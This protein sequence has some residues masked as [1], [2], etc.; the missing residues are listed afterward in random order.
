M[1]G[2]MRPDE[3]AAAKKVVIPD[4]VWDA[5]NA[6]IASRFIGGCAIVPQQAVVDKLIAAGFNEIDIFDKGWLNV[7][8]G[9]RALGWHVEYDKPGWNE[10][11]PAKYKFTAA[12]AVCATPRQQ[13]GGICEE[14]AT[15]IERLRLELAQAKL[16]E[17]AAAN[18]EA[19]IL[20]LR[21]LLRDW[22]E[23][24]KD[25]KPGCAAGA[26]WLESLRKRTALA[27]GDV[28]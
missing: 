26:D 14:A 23:F 11:Y 18:L 8:D 24:A 19:E 13:E 16:A 21:E 2:P 25:V 22:L 9:Y 7:E 15:E 5:F 10:F 3:V 12:G 1:S 6:E 17:D 27:P 28:K 20:R 4:A